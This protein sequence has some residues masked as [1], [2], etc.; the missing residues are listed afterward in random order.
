MS[1]KLIFLGSG[2]AFTVENYHSNILLE[3]ADHRRLLIDCGSDARHSLAEQGLKHQDINDVYVSHL[4]ADHVGGL[5][6]LGFTHYMCKVAKPPNL[7]IHETLIKSLWEQTLR[8]GMHSI[9]GEAASINTFFKIHPLT[10]NHRFV[11]NKLSFHTVQ[12]VHTYDGAELNPSYGLFF[13]LNGTYIF[14]TTDTQF[15]PKIMMPFYEQ[16]DIIFHDCETSSKLN[17]TVHA[18]FEELA[19]LPAEIKQKMWLYHY[20]DGEKPDA[21]AAGF[22]GYVMKGM[23]FEF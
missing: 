5:E 7:Y 12:T 2:S 18:R 9:S 4:H 14:I 1:I 3:T 17:S 13:A 11:W 22:L 8:G 6:W 20:N 16:A 23:V 15:I 19:Q 10:N 21:K